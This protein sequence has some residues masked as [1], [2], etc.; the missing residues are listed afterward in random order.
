[1][2]ELWRRGLNFSR[3]KYKIVS[4][5]TFAPHVRADFKA[6]VPRAIIESFGHGKPEVALVEISSQDKKILRIKNLHKN[7]YSRIISFKGEK[8]L[9]NPLVRL[10]DVK[11]KEDARSRNDATSFIPECT[12]TPR[13]T[14]I[15]VFNTASG[16]LVGGH[17]KKE[18][19]IK[20]PPYDA[21]NLAALGLYLAEGGKTV[22][23]FTNTW[24]QAI[25]EVLSYLE[26]FFDL[27]REDIFA[28]ICCN[29][30]ANKK[31]LEEFWAAET[32][33]C[34]FS[35]SL[36]INKNVKSH[37]G[38]LELHFCSQVL[39]EIILGIIRNMSDENLASLPF[40]RGFLSGDGSPTLQ[41]KYSITHHIVFNRAERSFN[42]KL[43]KSA[44]A[45]YNAKIVSGSRIV[46]YT[47]WNM[48]KGL[49]LND[50]YRFN[51]PNRLKFAKHFLSLPKTSVVRDREVSNYKRKFFPKIVN[52]FLSFQKLLLDSELVSENEFR[53]VSDEILH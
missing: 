42:E 53:R 37:H 17:Y 51:P 39:K 9:K 5:N 18:V 27:D 16:I 33:I 19:L 14:P 35:K 23:S 29:T 46:L 20:N 15:Y 32:G 22:A 12:S 1:M 11:S 25:N 49:L 52:E 3:T 40:L 30:R 8:E 13:P 21:T 38:I 43:A 2:N 44:F 28:T 50:A 36:H 41:T 7:G 4:G 45:S 10:L 47:S 34:N 48:N 6:S 24:P 26:S 31:A